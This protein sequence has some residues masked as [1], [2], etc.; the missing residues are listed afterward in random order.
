MEPARQIDPEGEIQSKALAIP[1]QARLIKV[2]DP[3]TMEQA[4]KMKSVIQSM[5]K[6]VDAFFKPMA[7]KAFA[8]HRAITGKWGEVKKPL[9]EADA[10][11]TGEV[12]TFQRVERDRIDTAQRAL[13]AYARKQAEEALIREAEAAEK[14]GFHE[15]AT[16]IIEEPI[17]VQV[18]I[19][20]SEAPKVDQ[21]KYRTVWKARVTDKGSFM[22]FVAQMLLK[23]QALE[24]QGKKAEAAA[25]AD[26]INA[27]DINQSW[28]N[29]KA[30]ALEKNFSM[31]G[32]SAYEE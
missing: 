27:L 26:Y 11:I 21:R 12:K 28:L 18:P 10:Y 13:E 32:C 23:A 8:T 22:Q 16:A 1:D 29:Q 20:K 14:A 3:A 24:T 2:V 6:D 15:E 31:P 7:E 19:V 17:E 5:R 4:D 30:R 9:D 25:Y